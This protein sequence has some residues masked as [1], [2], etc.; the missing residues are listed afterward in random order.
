MSCSCFGHDLNSKRFLCRSIYFNDWLDW[1]AGTLIH[2]KVNYERERKEVA[3]SS[4]KRFLL[5][6]YSLLTLLMIEWQT[7]WNNEGVIASGVW[8]EKGKV[9]L[10][11]EVAVE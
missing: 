7:N 5:I 1:I 2:V 9:P 11:P 6:F 8:T 4:V 10:N 3:E